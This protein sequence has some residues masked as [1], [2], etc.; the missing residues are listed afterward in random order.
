MSSVLATASPP[1]AMISSTTSLRGPVVAAGAVA[2]DAEVVHDDLGALAR[3]R[4]R[5][6]AA[7]AAAGA[8]DDDDASFADARRADHR[9]A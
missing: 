4:E 5:V 9:R 6:L 3:E 8:G 1:A 2:R 7:D